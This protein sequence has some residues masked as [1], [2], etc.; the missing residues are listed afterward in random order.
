MSKII[1][2]YKAYEKGLVCKGFQ[3]KEGE[4]Y[5]TEEAKVCEKGF[6]LCVNPLDCL[7]YYNLWDSE[8]TTAEALGKID[9]HKEDTKIATTKIKIG[10][11]LSFKQFVEASINFLSDITKNKKQY[12]SDSAQIGSS[13]GFAQIGS[14]G[15]FAK[16]ELNGEDSVGICAGPE[17]KIKG[18]IGNWITLSEWIYNK[19]KNRYVPKCVKSAQIDG[20]IIKED[21]WYQLIDG[22]FKECA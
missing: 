5:E 14:S 16:I 19:N 18:K 2:G 21:K 3:F 6:H 8:F 11:K 12:S 7:N 4:T 17:S 1:K 22:D 9:T 13:G 10:A 15:D 20:I